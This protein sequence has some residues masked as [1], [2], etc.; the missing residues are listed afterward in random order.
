MLSRAAS[1]LY[2]IGLHIERADFTARLIE[3][4]LQFDLLPF[5]ETQSDWTSAMQASGSAG[6]FDGDLATATREMVTHFLA[7]DQGNPSSI[8]SCL[9]KARGRSEEHT[10]ELQSLMRISYAVFCLK[11]KN[12]KNINNKPHSIQSTGYTYI[13]SKPKHT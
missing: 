9:E 5:T 10:S 2:W 13:I 3:A 6:L 1:S 8:I 7:F 4:A 12:T 11:K